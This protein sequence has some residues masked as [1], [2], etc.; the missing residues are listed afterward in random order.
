VLPRRQSEVS[1]RQWRA[2]PETERPRRSHAEAALRVPMEISLAHASAACR[3]CR[4]PPKAAR[5]IRWYGRGSDIEEQKRPENRAAAERCLTWPNPQGRASG[6]RLIT[7]FDLWPTTWAG[8]HTRIFIF[9]FFFFF[10]FRIFFFR[11]I[12]QAMATFQT[13]TGLLFHEI[14]P[15]SRSVRSR[16]IPMT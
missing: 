12:N 6:G 5:G 3:S 9:F 14:G 13:Q 10:F 7:D 2:L 11:S 1:K 4:E 16:F 15:A 8:R